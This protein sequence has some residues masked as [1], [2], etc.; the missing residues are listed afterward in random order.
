MKEKDYD[1]MEW[2]LFWKKNIQVINNI[3]SQVMEISW[4]DIVNYKP[5]KD[6]DINFKLRQALF[7][8]QERILDITLAIEAKKIILN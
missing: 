3:I 5:M 4:I 6:N 8:F 1:F 7:E 2:V